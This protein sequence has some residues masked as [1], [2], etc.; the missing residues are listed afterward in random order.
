MQRNLSRYAARRAF[1][2]FSADETGNPGAPPTDSRQIRCGPTS[3]RGES[4]L[5]WWHESSVRTRRRR[6]EEAQG[7]RAREA[8]ASTSAWRAGIVL[9]L[10][11][12]S[13]ARRPEPRI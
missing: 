4:A 7:D 5:H 9:S 10:L 3:S 11:R 1:C 6:Y 13:A 2:D 8:T 12:D